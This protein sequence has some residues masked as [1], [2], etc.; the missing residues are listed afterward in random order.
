MMEKE[1]KLTELVDVDILQRIQD[2]FS[3]MTGIAALTTDADGTAVTNG[4]NFSEFCMKHTRTSALGCSR[5]E[6]CDKYGAEVAL[7]EGK[8]VTYFCHA[9]LVDFAAPIMAN[10]EM[11]GCFIGGQVLSEPSDE[12]KVRQIAQEIGVDPEEYVL[13]ARKVNIIPKENIDKAA[14]F[15]YSIAG[16]LSEITYSRYLVYQANK[17]IEKAANMKSDF[18]ANMSHEIRTPM[19]AVIGMAEMA[20]REKLPDNARE[21]VNEI[22]SASK[23]LLTIIN[24]IL[25]FS[26]IESGKMDIVPV[27]YEPMSIINDITNIVMTRLEDKDV[28]LILDVD[29]DIPSRLYGDN[30]RIKQV[31]LNIANNAVKF[32]RKGQV[33]LHVGFTWVSETDIIL[34]I[35]VEDTGIGIKKED[36]G[37][38]FQSFQ[39]LDSKRNRNIEG[40]G[41]GLAIS[42]Q[43]LSL[44]GG[45]I[46]VESEYEKGSTFSF[47][48]PQKVIDRKSS[49]CIKDNRQI[50]AAGLVANSY[51]KQQ[52][53]SSIERLGAEYMDL[54]GEEELMQLKDKGVSYLFVETA[55]LTEGVRNFI[56]ENQHITA[57]LITKAHENMGRDIKN[58]RIVKKP[59]YTLNLAMIFNDES[60]HFDFLGDNTDLF[61][62][63]APDAEILIVDDN[64]INLTVAEGLLEPLKMKI[65]TAL[66][67]K[68]AVE[69]ISAH[70]YDIVFM[71]HMMPDMD[72]VETTHIIRRF[73]PEY[74]AVPIIALTANAVG[75]TMEMF[76]QEGMNDFV[77]KPIEIRILVSRVKKWLP[78]EKIQKLH[79]TEKI[80]TKQ[81]ADILPE[82][83]DLDVKSAVQ[84]LGSEKLF[85]SVLRDYYRVIEQKTATIARLEA[86]ENW[87]AYTIEVHALKSASRQIGANSLADKAAR[88]EQAGNEKNSGLIHE[89]TGEML[90]QY[91]AY[92]SVLKPFFEESSQNNNDGEFITEEV[93]D[94]CFAQLREATDNLD[95]DAMEAVV[96]EMKK[97]RYGEKE[98][99]LF[100]R[101][102]EAVENIDVDACEEI[103]LEWQAQ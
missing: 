22:K 10:D 34:Q 14:E 48:I 76:L 61:D 24:D 103:L 28:E 100:A 102:Q 2:A 79:M 41:L 21:Y 35:S 99:N 92:I 55:F 20:L 45:S 52:M 64:A 83:G 29:P 38:L 87:T 33:V 54:A 53:R 88:L 49:I 39:Q 51:V 27:E 25:D 63:V 86:E 89:L 44:M 13:A 74:D 31:I 11:I 94:T 16:I 5:C 73:H 65:D 69:K 47:E 32:T 72:G 26:K 93:L 96:D 60:F 23:S 36:L 37:K 95:I 75:G 80:V 4:S 67:G 3:R 82:I 85:F 78:A 91:S 62:F 98:T 8:S 42:K 90:E 15:L 50:V 56:E 58:I 1:L 17:E 7:K 6:K 40:T 43:L 9:G 97:Y 59:I 70:K 101:L 19:N 18:L 57:V 71:D 30:D 81:E 68:E 66:S 12:D 77:A 84:L 46:R